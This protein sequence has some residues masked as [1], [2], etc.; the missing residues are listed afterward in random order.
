[1]VLTPFT[2]FQVIVAP[3][4]SIVK[5]TKVRNVSKW[6]CAALTKRVQGVGSATKTHDFPHKLVIWQTYEIVA[7]FEPLENQRG[8]ALDVLS[9]CNLGALLLYSLCAPRRPSYTGQGKGSG[10]WPL[11]VK[12]KTG[13][14]RGI[15]PPGTPV[16]GEGTFDLIQFFPMRNEP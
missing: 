11:M 5:L 4:L 8:L 6:I 9:R 3:G 12:V 2:F 7:L 10:E 1:M 15:L 13:G 14:L 16:R